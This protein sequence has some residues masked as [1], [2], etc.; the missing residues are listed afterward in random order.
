VFAASAQPFQSAGFE[1]VLLC[2]RCGV[3]Q[4]GVCAIAAG[5]AIISAKKEP[6]SIRIVDLADIIAPSAV[7][8]FR[9]EA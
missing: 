7:A 2:A 8:E 3:G 1:A 5:A 6:R 4:R 9:E